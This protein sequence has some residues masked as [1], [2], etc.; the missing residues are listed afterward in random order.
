MGA[1]KSMGGAGCREQVQGGHLTLIG[2][3]ECDDVNDKP[4]CGFDQETADCEGA[5]QPA[6]RR[7]I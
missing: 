4:G 2:N 3:G 7:G 1:A 6:K 5:G